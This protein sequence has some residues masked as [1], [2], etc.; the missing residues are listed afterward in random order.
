[1]PWRENC[2]MDERIRFIGEQASGLWTMTELCERY[3][4]SRRTGYKWLDR[5]RA[6]GAAGLMERSR[7]PHRHGRSTASDLAQAI[8]D[9]RRERPSWGP[10][11]IIAKLSARDPSAAWPSA[12]TAGSILDRAGLVS[13]RRLFRRAPPRLGELTKPLHPNHVWAVDY[14]GWVRL[15]DGERVEPLTVTDSF[16]RYLISVSASSSTRLDEARPLFE[17]A[18]ESHGLPET[19]RSDNGTPFVGPGVTGLTSLSVWWIKLGIKHERIDAGCPQQNGRHERFHLTLLEAM[20]PAAAEPGRP[21]AA[22]RQLC[23]GL[24]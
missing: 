8:I 17:R 4:I 24:Q 15:G 10:R 13:R 12:S 6:E 2:A 21:G 19:I 22:L 20:R 9:L 16:S 23:A 5:Y 11:K 18:F 14:K 1:M 7:A 3:E